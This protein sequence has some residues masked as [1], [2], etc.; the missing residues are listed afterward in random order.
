MKIK[1]V[2]FRDLII[3][4]VFIHNGSKYMKT[5]SDHLPEDSIVEVEYETLSNEDVEIFIK[6]VIDR[7]LGDKP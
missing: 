6:E 4:S 1:E 7:A 3:G 2:V 5:R